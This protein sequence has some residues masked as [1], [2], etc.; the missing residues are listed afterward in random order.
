MSVLIDRYPEISQWRICDLGGSRHF[1]EESKVKVKPENVAIWNVSMGETDAYGETADQQIPIYLYDG[2]TIPCADKAYDLVI[3][4][5][6]LEHVP[7]GERE[8]LCGEMCRVA[9]R[10]YLQTP[11]YGF[12]FEPHFILP[13]VHWL[14]RKMGRRLARLSPWAILSRPTEAT[15]VEYFDGT[16]LL[17]RQEV[18]KL[19]PNAEVCVERFVGLPKS[20]IVHWEAS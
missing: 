5:S 4:N 2:R 13:F 10:V 12:P 7:P 18:V 14:P 1:W 3:C 20:Y 6:V 15:F 11:A 8:S 16:Q 19:F 17:T 9:K